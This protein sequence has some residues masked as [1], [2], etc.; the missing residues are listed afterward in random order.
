MAA[1][2]VEFISHRRKS[3]H[4]FL[5]VLRYFA[6]FLIPMWDKV[7]LRFIISSTNV[8]LILCIAMAGGKVI[9]EGL[10]ARDIDRFIFWLGFGFVLVLG[11]ALLSIVNGV[12]AGYINVRLEAHFRFGVFSHLQEHSLR[13]FEA[14]P[15]GEH[16]YRTNDDTTMAVSF[17][18]TFLLQLLERFVTVVVAMS[19]VPSLNAT[20]AL[21]VFAYML[22]FVPA[23]H[24]TASLVRGMHF[25]SRARTQESFAALQESLA[26]YPVDKMFGTERRNLHTYATILTTATRYAVRYMNFSNLFVN[27]VVGAPAAAGFLRMIFLHIAGV[28]LLGFLVMNGTLSTGEYV[29]LG[30]VLAAFVVPVE[31]MISAIANMRIWSV[32]AERMLETLEAAPEIQNKPTARRIVR[33]MGAIEFKDVSFRYEPGLPEVV[34]NLSFRIE[35]NTV[36]AFVGMSG[37]GKTTVFNLLMRYYDPTDGVVLIDGTDLREYDLRSYRD[38]VG[39]VLQESSLFSATLRDNVLIGHPRATE[40]EVLAALRRVEMDGFVGDLA[41]GLDTVLSEAGNLSMG[42][43]QRISIARA[44]LRNPRFLYLDEPTA[45]LDSETARQISRHLDVVSKGRTCVVIAHSL[46]LIMHADRILVMDHGAVVERGTHQSL[47]AAGSLYRTLWE[48]ELEKNGETGIEE[49]WRHD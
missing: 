19:I 13:F 45:S 11:A 7:L 37:A 27:L 16:M 6:P 25:A 20:V 33:P 28:V 23:A 26:G 31:E 1:E 24:F 22:V 17:V 21:I 10:V 12:I 4:A 29:F 38:H 40:D 41:E 35:P 18:G 2:S 32:P 5:H 30:G 34:H 8:F 3:F 44:L 39:L 49:A 9:D 42:D 15:I 46:Q 43:R 36:T 48:A 47:L 14:R